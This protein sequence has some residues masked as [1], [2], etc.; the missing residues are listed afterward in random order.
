MVRKVNCIV[1]GNTKPSVIRMP[2]NYINA[3][4]DNED[5]VYNYEADKYLT[6]RAEVEVTMN[7]QTVSRQTTS[8]RSKGKSSRR[9]SK[10]RRNRRGG[11][12]N[13]TVRSGQTLSEIAR[14]N[15]TTVAKLKRLN[16]IKGSNIR[17]GKKLRVK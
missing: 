9:G 3:F 13:V 4:I 5:S 16:G 17:A 8:V 1:N 11:S 10:A 15:H 6:K 14:R 2:Q 12:K 7:D